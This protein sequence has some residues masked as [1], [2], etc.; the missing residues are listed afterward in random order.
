[1]DRGYYAQSGICP[2]KRFIG[3]V[4]TNK[5]GSECEFEFETEDD[6][7]DEERWAAAKEAMFE[8]LEWSYDEAK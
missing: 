8:Q 1:M 4:R 6:A 2:M 3:W 5:V 7:T